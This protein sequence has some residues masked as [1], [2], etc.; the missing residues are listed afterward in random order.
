[1]TDSMDVAWRKAAQSFW[2]EWCGRAGLVAKGL[3]YSLIGVL[4]LMVALGFGGR[5]KDRQGALR[6]IADQPLGEAILFAL[7]AGF[8]GYAIW[9]FAQA[10][11]DRDNEGEGLEGLAKRAGYFA[12]G[13]LYAGLAAVSLAIVGGLGGGGSNEAQET[14]KIFDWPFGRALVYAAGFVLLG[15]AVWNGYRALSKKY[16]KDMKR[17]QM[18]KEERRTLDALGSAGH[19]ARMIVFGLVG[20]F[21]VR[22]AWEYDPNEAVGID[23]AL[24]RV[25]QAT[26]G[27]WLLAV[28]AGGLLAY[29]LFCFMQARYREV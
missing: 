8:A 10:F 14:D 17:G 19:L 4:A 23:G 9:R 25:A 20:F 15:A 7:A 6:F 21:F 3:I 13:L 12:R 16:R 1:M 2:V 18:S 24:A 29:G 26:Y 22:A 11:L 28:V 27:E 5:P